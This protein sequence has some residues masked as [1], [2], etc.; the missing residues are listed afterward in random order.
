[1]LRYDPAS[2][3]GQPGR[4]GRGH[5]Q[6]RRRRQV[7]SRASPGPLDSVSAPAASMRQARVVGPDH[8]A[9]TGPDSAA[10]PA[11]PAAAV[12]QCHD[13]PD[14]AAG[15]G[16]RTPGVRSPL[17][18]RPGGH[19]DRTVARRRA[20]HRLA[21]LRPRPAQWAARL[22]ARVSTVTRAYEP[23]SHPGLRAAQ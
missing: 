21:Q 15:G 18:T 17:S 20:A 10:R 5:T 19:G 14:R 13:Q 9:L 8:A 3:L 2:L 11:R 6:T 12:P 23:R 4:R 22:L 1:M 16:R 7:R